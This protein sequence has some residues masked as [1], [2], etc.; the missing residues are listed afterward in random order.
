MIRKEYKHENRFNNFHHLSLFTAL[1]DITAH[2]TRAPYRELSGAG[3]VSEGA[4]DRLLR[5]ISR[6]AELDI[7]V[8][9]TNQ[10]PP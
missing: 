9:T 5:C 4:V 3:L 10:L 1:K 8:K 2:C 6:A 7:D